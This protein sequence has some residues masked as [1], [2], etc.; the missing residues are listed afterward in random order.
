LIAIK[1]HSR[2]LMAE[3][4]GLNC[5]TTQMN[6]G[7]SVLAVITILYC[8]ISIRIDRMICWGKIREWSYETGDS[9]WQC[10]ILVMSRNR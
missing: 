10:I 3:K 5:H 1:A 6:C 9:N 4:E 8:T 7:T 2:V